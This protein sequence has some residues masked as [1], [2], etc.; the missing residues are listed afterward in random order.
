MAKF[1]IS[2]EMDDKGQR[3]FTVEQGRKKIAVRLT[4]SD[5]DSLVRYILKKFD[6]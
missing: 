5:A 4:E 6:N 3:N 1:R 2:E